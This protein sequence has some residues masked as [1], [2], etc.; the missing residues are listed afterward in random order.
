MTTNDDNYLKTKNNPVIHF[1]KVRYFCTLYSGMSESIYDKRLF[2]PKGADV[3]KIL[4][5]T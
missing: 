1:I 2:Y 4:Y 3:L 5:E